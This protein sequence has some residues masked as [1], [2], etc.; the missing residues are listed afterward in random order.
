MAT[1]ADAGGLLAVDLPAGQG[2][3]TVHWAE[4][5]LR[6][7]ADAL[8]AGALLAAAALA[9]W[10]RRR[11][12]GD[13]QAEERSAEAG[14]GS[15]AVPLALALAMAAA[16]VVLLAGKAIVLDRTST[17][18]L[19]RVEG[20]ALAG[21]EQPPWRVAGQALALAGYRLEAPD[22]LTLYWLALEDLDRDYTIAVIAKTPPGEHIAEVAHTHPGLSLTSRWKAGRLVRDAYTLDLGAIERPAALRL[23]AQVREAAT[24]APLPITDGPSAGLSEIPVGSIRLPSEATEAAAGLGPVGAE[25]GGLVAL[26][27]AALP[28]YAPQGAS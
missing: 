14:R 28:A 4:T 3:L 18:L 15:L 11:P 22:R 13:R 21:L 23:F 20:Q 9:A 1:R 2:R 7:V 26:D 25:F 6:A 16:G 12:A 8:S 10:P 24:G 17:P 27:G 19:R 5:P